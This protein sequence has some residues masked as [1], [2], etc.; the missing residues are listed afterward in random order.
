LKSGELGKVLIVDDEILIRQGIKHYLN[1]EKEGLTIVGEASNGQE[2]LDLIERTNPHIVVTDIVMPIMDGEQLTRMVKEKYPHI[3]VIVLSSFGDFDYVRSSFQSGVV[4]YILKPKLD[5]ESLLKALKNAVSRIPSLN[6]INQ[7][8]KNHFSISQL[9]N[10]IVSG[11]EV[12]SQAFVETAEVPFRRFCLLGMDLKMGRINDIEKNIKMGLQEQKYSIHME[13]NVILVNGDDFTEFLQ[14]INQL[15]ESDPGIGFVLSEEFEDLKLLSQIYKEDL[16]KL[17]NYRYY[18]SNLPLLRKSDIPI[19][20]PKCK[21]F[22][23]DGFT[24]DIK[25][26]HFESAF[27]Y[28][29]EHVKKL[30]ICYTTDVHE[31]KDFFGNII[32]NVTIL[33]SN[34]EYHVKEL[35][36]SRYVYLRSIEE[37]CSAHEA[38]EILEEFM[39]EAK[40]SIFSVPQQSENVNIKKIL[41]YIHEHFSEPITLT[42]VAQHFHFNPSYLSSYFSNHT[43][44]GFN[45]YLN[46]VRIEE[47]SKLLV[48]RTDTISEISVKVGY[49]DHSY[50]CKVFKK[51]KGLSPSQYRRTQYMR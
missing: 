7:G 15:A 19:P 44:E 45:E 26:K 40:K 28:L 9:L 12:D 3:E 29:Q 51:I 47:A 10:K 32:F 43:H 8:V 31:Y 6:V 42:D 27:G 33:L 14:M 4:D 23:L 46:K 21:N 35:E 36:Q 37:S 25:R 17:L 13:K 20:A 34:M 11:Y 5:A 22:N 30:S 41:D 18:F 16:L 24:S 1:W 38:I 48:Q 49:S 50:F 39:N 2:A